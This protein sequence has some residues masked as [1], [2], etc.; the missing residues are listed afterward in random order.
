MP[1]GPSSNF[2]VWQNVVNDAGAVVH[3]PDG[4]ALKEKVRMADGRLHDGTP[5]SFYFPEGH[6]LHGQFKGMAVILEER[7]YTNARELKAQCGK[8]FAS[9]C[10]KTPEPSGQ[11]CCCRRILYNEPDFVSVVSLVEQLCREAGIQVIFLPKF[12]CELN[13][14]EQCWGNAKQT[15]RDKPPTASERLMEQYITEALDSIDLR[16]IRR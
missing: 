5:Q 2:G 12:H 3:G 10:P 1:K 7:G 14:I 16:T 11:R 13:C 9:G 15:Y 6:E 8:D 4:K